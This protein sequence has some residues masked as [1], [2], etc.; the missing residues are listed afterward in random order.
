MNHPLQLE[1]VLQALQRLYEKKHNG[2]LP[3]SFISSVQRMVIK[4]NSS[5]DASK[6][7]YEK[8]QEWSE[9]KKIKIMAEEIPSDI[10]PEGHSGTLS[11][12]RVHSHAADDEIY[13]NNPDI[14]KMIPRGVCMLEL[15]GET[16]FFDM[17]LYANKKFTGGV[18]D[19][20]E[21]Q[22]ESNEAWKKY[23]ISSPDSASLVVG[24]EKLNGEAAHFSGRYID[25]QFFIITGSKNVHILIRNADDIDKYEGERYCVAKQ[26]ARAVC[27]TLKRLEEYP[28]HLVYS[29]L[30]HTKC[31]AVC[32]ILQPNYQHIVDLSYLEEPQ[33][34]VITFTS[35]LGNENE[36]SL[37]ALPPHYTLEVL[38]ILGFQTPSFSTVLPRDMGSHQHKVKRL[39]N[40]EGEVLYFIN[41]KGETIG[42][43]K[44]KSMWYVMMRALREKAIFCFLGAKRRQNW[45][46]ESM[47]RLTRK[48]FEEIQEWLNFSEEYLNKWKNLGALFLKWLEKEIEEKRVSERNIQP[49]FPILWARFMR[50]A[51]ETD[52]FIS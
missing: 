27:D 44:V 7:L 30:H 13:Y 21:S 12:L 38:S 6:N 19:E 3:E 11:D 16:S 37:T 24:M 15:Q 50:E 1:D 42:M 41:E 9:E 51:D 34:N 52:D 14:Q 10:L 4:A 22:P 25:D 28:R 35:T 23:C 45:S 5:G 32:E 33:L 8:A 17:V 39:L 49:Q 29:F 43:A 18:G 20:D 40:S 46:L 26:V 48:R 36:S 47:I 31:T 2:R